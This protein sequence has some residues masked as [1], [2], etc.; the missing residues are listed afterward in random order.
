VDFASHIGRGSGTVYLDNGVIRGGDAVVAYFGKYS[1]QERILSATVSVLKH[2][3]GFS[4]LGDAESFSF[5]GEISGNNINGNGTVPGTKL[6][7]QIQLRKVA[8]L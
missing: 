5:R 1:T 8:E 3:A 4:I 7:A 2:G 6:Q